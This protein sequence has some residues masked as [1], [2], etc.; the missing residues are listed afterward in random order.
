MEAPPAQ[1]QFLVPPLKSES[2]AQHVTSQP[3]LDV[4]YSV[5][6][7]AQKAGH[8]IAPPI[9]HWASE[10]QEMQTRK[11]SLKARSFFC[12]WSTQTQYSTLHLADRKLADFGK[13]R[14]WRGVITSF[15]SEHLKC[16][17]KSKKRKMFCSNKIPPQQ[18][19]QK[20]S[21]GGKKAPLCSKTQNT[22]PPHLF[23]RTLILALLYI[24]TSCCL[25]RQ[26]LLFSLHINI[27]P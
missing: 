15:C 5:G 6:Y 18:N 23:I 10:T 8:K 24:F 4:A 2:T 19:N 17:N 20:L 1:R 14:K 12:E 25:C 7:E 22:F 11:P 21:F 16:L 9:P 26:T 3:Q 27:L 13:V